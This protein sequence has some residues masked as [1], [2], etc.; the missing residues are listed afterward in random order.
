M[1]ARDR[2]AR[3]LVLTLALA[4]G[5]ALIAGCGG[6]DDSSEPS[7]I[8]V[9]ASGGKG[10]LEVTAP[11]EA[12]AGPAEI[13][14]TNSSEEG[15]LDGQLVY[16]AEGE[17]HTDMEVSAEL[18]KAVEGQP[19]ADWFQA[20][21][22]PGFAGKGESSTATVDLQAGTYYFV[23][24]T[25]DE[26]TLPLTKFTVT[27]ESDEDLPDADATVTAN[28]YSF[29]SEGLKAGETS[30]LLENAGAQW[31]HFLAS[32]LKEDATIEQAREFL[33]T[34]KGEPPFVE[35]GPGQ[36]AGANEVEST[37][38]EGGVSEVVD[39]DLLPGRY[40]FFCFIADKEGGPPHVAKGMVSEVEVT[41]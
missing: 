33:E 35:Q 15:E 19:V 6:D 23:P 13:T 40:A 27:G 14:F 4:A 1:K 2:S 10:S 38:L 34:E 5:S 41:E 37:V 26:P 39:L 16:V 3:I 21:G 18:G 29:S 32:P 9:E 36:G 12:E 24:S 31:H 28:E 8:A 17:D 7:S 20:A 30:V 25:D 22:G 11:S